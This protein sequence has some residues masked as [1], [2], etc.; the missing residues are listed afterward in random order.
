M[1]REYSVQIRIRDD[2]PRCA[3]L[4]AWREN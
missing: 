2:D 3:G 4:L 1:N